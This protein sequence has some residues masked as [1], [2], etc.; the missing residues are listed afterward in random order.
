M[1]I[2]STPLSLKKI[3]D[4]ENRSTEKGKISQIGAEISKVSLREE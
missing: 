1:S 2:L 3:E 4:E